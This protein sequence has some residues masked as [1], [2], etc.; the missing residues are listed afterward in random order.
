MSFP[1]IKCNSPDC[2][3]TK[4]LDSFRE[5]LEAAKSVAALAMENQTRL[6]KMLTK[7]GCPDICA[8]GR[9]L[10]VRAKK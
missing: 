3:L 1:D 6:S 5:Q 2:P 9:I 4:V 10:R 7:R 8:E